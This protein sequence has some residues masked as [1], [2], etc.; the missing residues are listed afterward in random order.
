[1][2]LILRMLLFVLCIHGF[3]IGKVFADETRSGFSLQPL[4]PTQPPQI[5]PVETLD[6]NYVSIEATSDT[7]IS[8]SILKSFEIIVKIIQDKSYTLLNWKTYSRSG[9]LEIVNYDRKLQFGRWINDP[10]DDTCFNTRAKV[11]LRDSIKEVI[12]KDHDHCKV[13]S[14]Y[15][16][17]PYTNQMY[18]SAKEIQIDHFVP[19]KN[20]YISGAYNWSFKARCLYANYLGLDYH[21]LSVNGHQNMKKGDKSPEKYLPPNTDYICTYIKN[22]LSIKFLWGLKMSE[23]EASAISQSVKD[24]NCNLHKFRMS[25]HEIFTQSKFVRENIDLCE[26]IVP[27]NAA[28]TSN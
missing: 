13:E 17:D 22:W 10:N 23:T 21:L 12:F 18:L 27:P 1:M 7:S 3:S 8:F 6:K 4:N 14:G 24:N 11:L 5:V 19:L 25:Q 26:K 9:S 2:K 16:P 28:A 20:A 15:W